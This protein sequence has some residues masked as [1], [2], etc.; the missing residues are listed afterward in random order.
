MYRRLGS[1][2]LGVTLALLWTVALQGQEFRATIHG[3]IT[4]PRGAVVA[5]AK[6]QAINQATNLAVST[7]STA[8]GDYT[9]PLLQPGTYTLEVDKT[10]FKD[11]RRVGLVLDTGQ[12]AGIDVTMQVG[13]QTQSVE[14]TAETPVLDSQNA[15]EGLVVTGTDVNELPLN[16]RNPFMLTQLS[17]GSNYGGSEQFQRPFDNGA[18]AGWSINGGLQAS[19]NFL[20]DGAPNNAQAGGNN[21]AWVTPV[22]SVSEFKVQTSSY[23]A[24]YGRTA[25]GIV[26]VTTK[27][28]GAQYHG[29]GYMFLRRTALDAL[30]PAEKDNEAEFGTAQTSVDYLNEPGFSLGGPVQIPKLYSSHHKTFFFVNY[31]HYYQDN[32]QQEEYSVPTLQELG[33]APGETGVYDF[34]GLS[35]PATD[36]GTAVTIYNPYGQAFTDCAQTPGGNVCATTPAATVTQ[37]G[38]AYTVTRSPFVIPNPFYGGSC[39]SAPAGVPGGSFS[40]NTTSQTIQGIPATAVNPIALAMMAL[41]PAANQNGVTAIGATRYGLDDYSGSASSNPLFGNGEDHFYN[42]IARIDQDFGSNDHLFFRFGQDDRH[43]ENLSSAVSGIGTSGQN[44]L[45]RAN[46]AYALDWSHIFSPTLVSDWRLS[47][48]RYVEAA[49]STNDLSVTP[50][51]LGFSS[52]VVA[53]IPDPNALGEY[54]VTNYTSLGKNPPYNVNFTNTW[55]MGGK[56]VKQ[57]G[58]HSLKFGADVQRIQENFVSVGANFDL[59]FS[60][61]WTQ[62]NYLTSSPS[63]GDGLATLLLG[64]PSSVEADNLF[65]PSYMTPYYAFFTQDDWRVS[66]RLTL[67]LGLRWDIF[68]PV[69]EAHGAIIDGWET[70]ANPINGAVQSNIAAFSASQASTFATYFPSGLPTLTGGYNWVTNNG[71]GDGQTAWNGLQPRLGFAYSAS[72]RFVLRGGWA[73]YMINPT[74][75]WYQNPPQGYSENI[76]YGQ[77]TLSQVSSSTPAD[78]LP[79]GT[80]CTASTPAGCSGNLLSNPFQFLGGAALPSPTG[81]TLGAQTGLGNALNYFNTSFQP[82]SMDDFDLGVQVEITNASRIDIAYVG[83]RSHNLEEDAPYNVIPES[84]RQKCDPLEGGNPNLCNASVPNPFYGLSAFAGSTLGTSSTTTV[85]QLSVPYPE[86]VGTTGTTSSGTES[87]LNVGRSWYNALQATYTLRAQRSLTMSVA[88]TWSSTIEEGGVPSSTCG[89]NCNGDAG[90]AYTDVQEQLLERSPV[91]W[92]LPQTLKVSSVWEIPVG[93]GRRF[94]GNAGG[95]VDAVLGGWEHNMFL[96]YNSGH[97]W[98]LP[99]STIFF[100]QTGTAYDVNLHADYRGPGNIVQGIRPCVGQLA[101]SSTGVPSVTLESYSTANGNPYNCAVSNI[102]FLNIPSS[103]APY[104]SP[105]DNFSQLGID[106]SPVG[107]NLRTSLIRTQPATVADMSIGKTFRVYER[108]SVQF[109][110][111]AFNAFNTPWMADSQ[112]TSTVTSSAFGS[113]TKS[114]AQNGAAYPLREIQLGFKVIF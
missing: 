114:S 24:E 39:P 10:G 3:R 19:N 75:D 45:I 76:A 90:T 68:P 69:S 106:G 22:D 51:A 42:L 49:N 104:I 64:L 55:D 44:P 97:P 101:V 31:E 9:I 110:A 98:N 95:L 47:F 96:Q 113:L 33:E 102:N 37:K 108:A 6:I 50:A 103:L 88:Y 62:Q 74:N 20:L 91:S 12:V 111:E 16:G 14:V 92:D 52:S 8:D 67:N 77:S 57:L 1:I 87:G 7:V 63:S 54:S 13:E 28:G 46:Y 72:S 70:T 60:D 80:P 66:K 109:R 32:P 40:C 27:A 29:T 105:T 4:D 41:V 59:G 99:A 35:N 30:T 53:Q 36:G 48:S 11:Y 26:N 2:A 79:V 43:Q 61:A 58:A 18:I 65:D 82:A 5:G 34:S 100:P 83:N 38:T 21:L 23:D 93:R 85:A 78:A 73:R 81:K 107:D 15:N 17:A 86:F 56:L 25:G 112:Y 84:L 71:Q 94:L 89:S